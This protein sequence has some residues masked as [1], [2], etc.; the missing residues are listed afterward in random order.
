MS[1]AAEAAASTHTGGVLGGAAT[2]T[3]TSRQPHLLLLGS[4]YYLYYSLTFL[5][6][7][8]PHTT[9]KDPRPA[10][11][12]PVLVILRRRQHPAMLQAPL[13]LLLATKA[14]NAVQ[15]VYTVFSA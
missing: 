2:S 10:L 5:P 14:H 12:P 3:G 6:L 11:R 1:A 15:L 13:R 8:V 4:R 7:H 9:S